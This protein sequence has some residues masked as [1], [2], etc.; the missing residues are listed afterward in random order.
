MLVKHM[1]LTRDVVIKENNGR[2]YGLG[3]GVYDIYRGKNEDGTP[4]FEPVFI[5]LLVNGDREVSFLENFGK[6]GSIFKFTGEIT[7][8]AP[9]QNK[10]S[11][12]WISTINLAVRTADFAEIRVG[13]QKEG[14]NTTPASAKTAQTAPPAASTPNEE[15]QNID[16]VFEFWDD[17]ENET[18]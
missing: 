1:R 4:K 6:K 18:A 17:E 11:G 3:S 2:K 7:P 12:D 15:I 5:N 10:T 9:Y 16:S 13:Q 14:S 8:G